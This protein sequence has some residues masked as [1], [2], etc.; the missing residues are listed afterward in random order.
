M[1]PTNPVVGTSTMTKLAEQREKDK[2]AH[3]EKIAKMTLA[4]EQILLNH[5]ATLQDWQEIEAKFNERAM[6]VLPELTIKFVKDR[7]DQAS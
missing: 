3:I 6:K 2:R 4:I 7:F 5:N 1:T